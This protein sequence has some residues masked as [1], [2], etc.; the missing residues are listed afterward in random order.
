M[1]L[2]FFQRV[3]LAPGLTLNFSKSGASLSIGPRGARYTIGPSGQRV[4]VGLPGSGLFYTVHEPRRRRAGPKAPDAAPLTLRERLDRGFFQRLLMPADERAFIDAVLAMD[5]GDD[6]AAAGHLAKAASLA[7]AA[8]LAG[9]LHLN[10][11][12]R[13]LARDRL[14]DALS[15]TAELGAS[16]RKLHLTPEVSLA[17]APEVRAHLA[18]GESSVR[19]ALVELE[20]AERLPEAAR[21]HLE[22]LLVL[23]P[24]DPVVLAAFAELAL[25]CRPIESG[26]SER[27]VAL[28][29]AIE[30]ETPIHTAVLFYR[31]QALAALGL[32]DAAVDTATRGLRRTADR[33]QA[34]LQQLRYERAR[35]YEQLGRKAQARRDLERL[36][37]EAPDYA[38]VRERLGLGAD[39]GS[40]GG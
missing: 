32:L 1:P 33:P 15:R 3:R 34:L 21:V 17:I 23:S 7:D 40:A 5:A 2:R 35:W 30:N 26:V 28:T 9:M 16:F 29:A 11:G 37:A 8:W 14:L 39:V 18:P 19:L 22:R 24:A 13:G 27:I 31:A 20:Q 6:E 10:R 36:Y 4:T 12:R 25:A 38:D